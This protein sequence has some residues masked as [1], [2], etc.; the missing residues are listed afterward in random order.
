MNQNLLLLTD[1]YKISHWKQYPAGTTKIFSYFESRGG[2]FPVT[3]FFGLQYFVRR[4]LVGQVISEEKIDEARLLSSQHFGDSSVFNYHGWM[5]LL[6]KHHGHL[7]AR[8]RA[9]PEGTVVPTRNVLMT[10][11]NTDPEFPWLTNYLETL[12]SNVWYPSTVA[13]QSR[14]MKMDILSSLTRT[15]DPSGLPFKLHDFGCRGVTCPE[16]AAL[17]GAAH[18]VNFVGTDT[19]PALMLAKDY[20]GASPVA[21]YS[22]PATEHSTM[23]IY[24]RDYE[25]AAVENHLEKFPTGLLAIVG[26]SYDIFNFCREIIGNKFHDKIKNRVGT[27]I[28]RPDS[29]NPLIV[30]PKVLEILAQQFGY[31]RNAKDF[32]LLPPFIRVIQGDGINRHTVVEIITELEK[33]GWSM[34]N[35]AFG[36]GGGLLQQVNRDTC[37]FA[38]KCSAAEVNGQW[39]DVYKDPVTGSDKKSKRGRLRLTVEDGEYFTTNE[40]ANG[41]DVLQTVFEDGIPVRDENLAQIRQRAAL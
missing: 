32:K 5:A 6:R 7:P 3:L 25:S 13:T 35:L 2:D 18:L 22:I 4:Y 23:T 38:F 40:A 26:D 31:T 14:A 17:G 36:S 27:I 33:Q 1:S 10:V 11:E 29:G 8:I 41:H 20:Y 19:L 30:L 16:Q 39:R 37:K 9:V 12:L 28:V 21:G 24:G 34:D 15:G